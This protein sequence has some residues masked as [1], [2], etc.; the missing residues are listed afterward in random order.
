MGAYSSYRM[1]EFGPVCSGS[2]KYN[3]PDYDFTAKD[4]T[5]ANSIFGDLV[6]RDNGFRKAQFLGNQDKYLNFIETKYGIEIG[7]YFKNI[8]NEGMVSQYSRKCIRNFM[9][10]HP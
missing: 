9:T 10:K 3:I 2:R 5:E 6:C 8:Y 7:N 4:E 1:D